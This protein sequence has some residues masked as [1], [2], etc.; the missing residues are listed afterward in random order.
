MMNDAAVSTVERFAT[1][2]KRLEL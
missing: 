1:A 2:V